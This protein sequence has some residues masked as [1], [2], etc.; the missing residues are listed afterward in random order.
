[1][2]VVADSRTANVRVSAGI[3]SFPPRSANGEGLVLKR[4]KIDKCIERPDAVTP[5]DFKITSAK[6]SFQPSHL[7]ELLP[8]E[9]FV[10]LASGDRGTGEAKINRNALLPEWDRVGSEP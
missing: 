7:S 9:E 6:N 10:D 2:T 3:G 5:H 1:M 4:K 8:V